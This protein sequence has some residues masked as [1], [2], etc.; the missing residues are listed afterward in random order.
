MTAVEV[1]D[2]HFYHLKVS[3]LIGGLLT[4]SRISHTLGA[5]LAHHE[6]L[7]P[8]LLVHL[9]YLILNQVKLNEIE[10]LKKPLFY[11]EVPQTNSQARK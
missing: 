1:W 2:S 9:Y 5:L 4:P 3:K 10:Q 7:L 8:G 6:L 11:S